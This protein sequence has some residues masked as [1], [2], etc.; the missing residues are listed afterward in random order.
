MIII[1]IFHLEPENSK[2]RRDI[3]EGKATETLKLDIIVAIEFIL[4]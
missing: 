3:G 2:D 1:M 4:I